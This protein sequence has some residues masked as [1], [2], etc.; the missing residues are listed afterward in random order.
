MDFKG[1]FADSHLFLDFPRQPSYRIENPRIF[2]RADVE[3]GMR[4]SS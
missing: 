1:F 3:S 2:S 4:R